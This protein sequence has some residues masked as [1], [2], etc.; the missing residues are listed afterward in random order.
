M[1]VCSVMT[2]KPHNFLYRFWL[3]SIPSFW[4]IYK[5][6]KLTGFWTQES[7]HWILCIQ[8]NWFFENQNTKIKIDLLEIIRR[9]FPE[10]L[11][12]FALI[13]YN[14]FSYFLYLYYTTIFLNSYVVQTDY[15]WSF[16]GFMQLQ[17]LPIIYSHILFQ[18]G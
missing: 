13:I 12:W 4:S 17:V 8:R 6:K 2:M 9:E 5:T 15:L 18:S 11:V 16:Q 14:N 10:N 3:N 7:T 1:S